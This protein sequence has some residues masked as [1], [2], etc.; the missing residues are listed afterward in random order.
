[1][2][3]SQTSAAVSATTGQRES[4]TPAAATRMWGGEPKAASAASKRD[5]TA[6]GS[7]TSARTA[8]ARGQ[9]EEEEIDWELISAARRSAAAELVE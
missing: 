9:R 1:M 8:T 6:E 3:A 7:E 4:R 2:A 5:L